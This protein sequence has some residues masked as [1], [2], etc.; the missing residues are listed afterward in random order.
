MDLDRA[1]AFN[2]IAWILNNKIVNENGSLIEFKDHMF[3]VDPYM[4]TTPRQVVEKCSQIGWSTLAILRSFHLC[5]YAGANIIHTFPSRNMAK[6]F[7]IPKVNP[8]ISGNPVISKMIGVDSV[9]LKQ[10]GKRY[11]YYRGCF[12]TDTKIL[13]FKGWENC[14]T[15]HTGDEIVTVN[16]ETEELELKKVKKIFTYRASE[17]LIS[18]TNRTLDMMVTD[19]H[20]CLV[21]K[22]FNGK[23]KIERADEIRELSNVRIPIAARP[24]QSKGITESNAFCKILGWVIGDGTYWTERYKNRFIKKDGTKTDKTWEYQRVC[25]IQKNHKQQLIKDLKRAGIGY[26]IK[27]NGVCEGF[28]LSRKDCKK[29]RSYMPDKKLTLLLIYSFS[30]TQRVSLYEGLMLA[31]AHKLNFYQK[32]Y[33]TSDNFRILCFLIGKNSGIYK[34]QMVTKFSHGKIAIDY[35]THVKSDRNAFKFKIKKVPYTG[36]VWCVETENGTVVAKKNEKIFLS[37][38]SYEEQEAIS[39]SAHILINDEFDRSNQNVL[40]IYRSRLD[41]AKREMPDLGWEWQFSNPSIPG[42]G[43]DVLW[44]KSDQK[45]WFVKC[46]H[47]NYD[48]YLTF[49]ENIDFDHQCRICAKCHNILDRESLRAG[50]WVNKVKSDIS[51]YWISQLFVPWIPASDII[52]DSQGD[53]DVFHNFTLGLPYVSKDIS[54]TREA[55]IKC[56]SPGYNPRTDVAIGVDNG[57]IKHYVIGNRYGIF[58]VGKT[59]DW[60]FIENMRNR[61]AATMVIDS[62]PYPNTPGKLARKYPGKVFVHYYQP[63]KKNIGVIRWEQYEV[64]SDRTKIIDSVVAEIN[65]MDLTFNMTEHALEEYIAHWKSVY[66]VILDTPQGIKRPSWETIEG[67][68]DHFAHATVYWRIALERTLG[69][70]GIVRSR[71]PLKPAGGHSSV[72]PDS[73][74]PALNLDEVARRATV[75]RKNWKTT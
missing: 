27:D 59:D 2:A 68:D 43:V 13:T 10:V 49:P 47:C 71:P 34:R 15:I 58:E 45:H 18:F 28:E 56:I 38:N 29:I 23:M 12:D 55:I 22:S 31:E 75:P 30:Y 5:R 46:P 73:T 70:G 62:M 16:I 1:S 26:Y 72:S 25:I 14:E 36:K 61:Y 3:L 65:S 60:D 44:Q 40:K 17:D 24:Y 20:R 63:D 11:I 66:R 4:D 41:D 54:V 9:S 6:D 37:G 33:Q 32:D 69:Q 21:R 52:D 50:R 48:W 35:M 7:V 57:V 51:G 53:Q 64:K 67:K 8:L 42:A 74:V 39:I 19:N